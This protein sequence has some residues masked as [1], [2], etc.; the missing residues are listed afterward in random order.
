MLLE[1]LLARGAR[2]SGGLPI[3]LRTELADALHALELFL[4]DTRDD[5]GGAPAGGPQG[6]PEAAEQR[7]RFQR[8]T[9]SDRARR[10][11]EVE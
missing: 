8:T 3:S 7:R 9:D 11:R 6:D 10:A 4:A 1:K 2:S 5:W